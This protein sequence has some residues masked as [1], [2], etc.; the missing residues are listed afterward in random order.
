MHIYLLGNANCLS[1]SEKIKKYPFDISTDI[2]PF[3]G[4]TDPDQAFFKKRIC[5]LQNPKQIQTNI[6]GSNIYKSKRFE[7]ME[8]RIRS[9]S[10]EKNLP[11]LLFENF[12]LPVFAKL[13]NSM[14]R[15][16]RACFAF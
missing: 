7:R 14:H 12:S 11:C 15:I 3:F 13:E 10:P 5:I 1:K 16:L 6:S 2:E 8:K 4:H 9:R